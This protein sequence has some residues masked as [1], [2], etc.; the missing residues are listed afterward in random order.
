MGPGF[1]SLLLPMLLLCVMEEDTE[2]GWVMVSKSRRSLFRLL[3]TK[4]INGSTYP[5]T[6][7]IF[8]GPEATMLVLN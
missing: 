8:K 2:P 7:T 4:L 5:E 3:S 1:S 6:W